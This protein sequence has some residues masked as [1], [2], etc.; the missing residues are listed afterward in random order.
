MGRRELVI[1]LVFVVLA[2]VAYQLTAPPL[3]EGEEG[4]SFS[5]LF[6]GIRREIQS[7]NA[8]ASITRAA[9]V[10]LRDDIK[11]VRL[12]VG[13]SVPITVTGER[14]D[15]LAYELWVQ[16]NGPDEAGAKALAEQTKFGPDDLGSAIALKLTFP[17]PG[18][19]TA[20]LNVRVPE[21]LLVR[22][23]GSG[24]AVVTG[25]RAL[26]MRNL[27]GETTISKVGDLVKGTHRQ[28]DLKISMTGAVDVATT[29]STVQ[30]DQI[31]GAISMNGRQGNCTITA[32]MGSIDATVT[33]VELS[34]KDHGGAIRV[35]GDGA[36]LKVTQPSK[37]LSVDARRMHVEV[38]LA[39][40]VPMTIITTDEPLKILFMAP[41]AAKIDATVSDRGEIKASD[42]GLTPT[43]A[44]REWRLTGAVGGDGPRLLLRN[45]RGD[46]VIGVR[47]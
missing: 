35:T 17:E 22:L 31:A 18:E 20:T 5:R 19:Q 6:S 25:V 24:R 43:R 40:A 10:K 12:N 29:G 33:N 42:I 38:A 14:R 32:S 21:R 4:F 46:I 44:D 39:A 16:S 1:A 41:P 34:I 47:K 36:F 8:K 45:T 28:G 7:N 27:A 9:T 13:R 23:E 15:D 2:V 3:K 37:E 30:L 11:E 26:E